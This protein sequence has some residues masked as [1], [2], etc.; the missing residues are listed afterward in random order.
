[1]RVREGASR[2]A[3]GF[4]ISVLNFVLEPEDDARRPSWVNNNVEEQL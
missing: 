2:N 4:G 3:M 1:M